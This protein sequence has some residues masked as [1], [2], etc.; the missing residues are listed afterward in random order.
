MA[1]LNTAL[2]TGFAETLYKSMLYD[3]A[4]DALPKMLARFIG[5][6][7]FISVYSVISEAS[8]RVY[9]Y[10]L[11]RL[12]QKPSSLREAAALMKL[13]AGIHNSFGDSTVGVPK[14]HVEII[15]D[16]EAYVKCRGSGYSVNGE[17]RYVPVVFAGLVGGFLEALGFRVKPLRSE[18]SLRF[19][20]PG[21]LGVL[22]EG[23]SRECV[24]KVVARA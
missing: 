6:G 15:S 1:S 14:I 3:I 17:H 12:P 16:H 2:D 7:G 9:N 20:Q 13:M 10:I 18:D 21:E 8:K 23:D 19:L 22:A 11:E 5:E 4:F 24:V